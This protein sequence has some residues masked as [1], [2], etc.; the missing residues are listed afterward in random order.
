[1]RVERAA[2]VTDVRSPD[3]LSKL[4]A[5][6]SPLLSGGSR[7]EDMVSNDGSWVDPWG[8]GPGRAGEPPPD[9]RHVGGWDVYVFVDS[10]D[11]QLFLHRTDR[12]DTLWTRSHYAA[13]CAAGAPRLGSDREAAVRLVDALARAVVGFQQP[14]AP[15]TAGLLT[16][17][18]LA[19]I[20]DTIEADLARNRTTAEYAQE[21]DA[22]TVIATAR[23]LGLD[24]RPSGKDAVTWTAACPASANH[25]L[26]ISAPADRFHCGYCRRAGGPAELQAFF[27]ET[28]GTRPSKSNSNATSPKE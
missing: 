12:Q 10:F 26:D 1:M 20:V 9:A 25:G 14:R 17:A 23:R 24:P 5:P 3:R 2:F 16:P 6:D 7:T 28:R 22:S 13:C 19:G 11:E 18:E 15:Y 4:G 8:H 21:A 27:D